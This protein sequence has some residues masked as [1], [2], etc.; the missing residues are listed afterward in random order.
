MA[1]HKLQQEHS[2]SVYSQLAQLL[3]Q[4]SDKT[5]SVVNE[6]LPCF[7]ASDSSRNMLQAGG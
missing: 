3:R 2:E 5:L 4:V 6:L 7:G 1:T